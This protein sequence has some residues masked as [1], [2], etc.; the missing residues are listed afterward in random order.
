MSTPLRIAGL[1]IARALAIIGMIILHMASLLWS[2]KVILSGLPAALFAILAGVTLMIIGRSYTTTTFLRIV[3]RGGIIALI[4][5]ALLPLGG[6]IQVVLV[7]MGITMIIVSWVPPLNVWWK[8]GLF[9]LAA[10]AATVRYAPFT[11]P[12]VYPMLTW[13]AYFLAGMLLFEVYIRTERTAVQWA[14]TAVGAV[15]AVAGTY[16]RFTTDIPNWL[17]FTGHTGVLGEIMLSVAVAAVVLHLCLLLGRHAGAL[18]YPLQAMGAMSLSVYILHVITAFFWQ[19]NVSLHSTPWAVAFIVLFL[20]LATL[21]RKV[22]GQGP[23]ERLVSRAINLAVPAVAPA[24]K[25]TAA[26]TVTPTAQ[27]A[28]ERV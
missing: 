16:F 1:D 23:V 15:V 2:T 9:A 6:S 14:A 28:V 25:S 18:T 26:P 13:I 22:A 17:R 24:A 19:Q 27:P 4:G 12:Q 11:L 10:A 3:A 5:L 21:W 7:A 8:L 20:V